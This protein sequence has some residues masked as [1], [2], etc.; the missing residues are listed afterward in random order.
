MPP[1]PVQND[2]RRHGELRIAVGEIVA[3]RKVRAQE[4][5]GQL[6]T[7]FDMPVP[8]TINISFPLAAGW[9][10]FYVREIEDLSRLQKGE[11]KIKEARMDVP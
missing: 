5:K 3:V 11:P 7:S 9:Q 2:V 6:P 10:Y 8:S 4:R 1:L